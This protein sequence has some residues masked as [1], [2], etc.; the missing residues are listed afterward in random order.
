MADT[1][2]ELTGWKQIAAY[3]EVTVRT[4]QKWER[5]Q[6]LPVRRMTGPRG[7]ITAMSDGLDRW[8]TRRTLPTEC[9]VFRWPVDQDIIAE[10]KF[11]GASPS[12]AH[13]RRLMDYLALMKASLAPDPTHGA[14]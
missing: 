1:P 2:R 3:L 10:V 4:A 9:F 8:R 13:V 7:R 5:Y 6:N 12:S 14:P 11:I